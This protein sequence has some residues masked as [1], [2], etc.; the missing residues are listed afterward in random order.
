MQAISG[1][2]GVLKAIHINQEFTFFKIE[3]D[4]ALITAG[5]LAANFCAHGLY[6]SPE[7]HGAEVPLTGERL[8]ACTTCASRLKSFTSADVVLGL[9]V[10]A[11]AVI[12]IWLLVKSIRA[13]F[14]NETNGHCPSNVTGF[15]WFIFVSCILKLIQFGQ[16]AND[17][18]KETE[19]NPMG[20]LACYGIFTLIMGL[21]SQFEFW[22]LCDDKL[23][24]TVAMYMYMSY[25]IAAWT[26]VLIGAFVLT[27]NTRAAGALE[28]TSDLEGAFED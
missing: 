17:S 13:L 25:G 2:Q 1:F 23:N 28:A 8:Q 26:A 18:D 5:W 16:N 20:I 19:T 12:G 22:N 9:C 11:Q 7:S 15:V 3:D 21:V 10:I 24:D 6:H 14:Y 4:F 27:A